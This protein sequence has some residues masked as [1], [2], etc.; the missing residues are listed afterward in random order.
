MRK[1]LVI[2]PSTV[3]IGNTNASLSAIEREMVRPT[4][5]LLALESFSASTEAARGATHLTGRCELMISKMHEQYHGRGTSKPLPLIGLHVDKLQHVLDHFNEVV[6]VQKHVLPW[7]NTWSS[8]HPSL[9]LLL[10]HYGFLVPGL[11]FLVR[12]C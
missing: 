12:N 6:D 4:I 10:I 5:P 9:D 3:G 11:S 7:Q 1:A 8:I 2:T